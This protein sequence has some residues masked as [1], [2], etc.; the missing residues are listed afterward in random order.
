MRILVSLVMAITGYIFLSSM[1]QGTISQLTY[2]VHKISITA[3][4]NT[5][6]LIKGYSTAGFAENQ[7]K[8]KYAFDIAEL[9]KYSNE[10]LTYDRL[11]SFGVKQDDITNAVLTN[12]GLRPDD[13]DNASIRVIVNMTPFIP[14]LYV[15]MVMMRAFMG[16]EGAERRERIELQLNRA[17]G[18][19]PHTEEEVQAMVNK[20]IGIS[21]EEALKNCGYKVIEISSNIRDNEDVG[22]EPIVFTRPHILNI[23]DNFEWIV[24]EKHDQYMLYKVMGM[25][26][27]MKGLDCIY[28]FGSDE[29]THT[30][31]MIRIPLTYENRRIETCRRWSIGANDNDIL[32][33]V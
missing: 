29:H 25:H 17:F 16:T 6:E 4:N 30:P 11:R 27:R 28:L 8:N 23:D 7:G 13:I 14:I 3:T 22:H 5:S 18:R 32:V 33:E 20:S 2:N 24:I 19:H 9:L 12:A 10:Q 15:I 26:K 21:F 1:T 31:F